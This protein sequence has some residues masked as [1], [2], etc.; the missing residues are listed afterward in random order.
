MKRA[1]ATMLR[2]GAYKPRTSPYDFQGLGLEALKILREAREQTGL[3]VVTE[4]M[5][6]EDVDIICEHA[7]MLQVGARNMQNFALLRRLATVEKADAVEAR[8]VGD[9]EGMA[10]GGGVFACLA[11]TAGGALRARDQDVRNGD[12]EYV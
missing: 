3:P 4:V 5:S 10:A 7:D 9:G 1:G 11:G 8:S 2:G 6:T 12:A